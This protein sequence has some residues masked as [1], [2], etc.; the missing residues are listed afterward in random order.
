MD[1]TQRLLNDIRT[2]LRISAA[3]A[4]RETAAKILDSKEK[5][6]VYSKLDGNTSQAKLAEIAKIPDRTIGGWCIVFAETG[7]ASEPNEFFKS[8]RA[9]FTLREL[10]IDVAKLKKEKEQPQSGG[11]DL[12]KEQEVLPMG[13]SKQ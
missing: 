10:K 6:L 9:L 13:D 11:I 8:H 12:K 3:S 2:Y 7:L 5:A 4:S 1:D